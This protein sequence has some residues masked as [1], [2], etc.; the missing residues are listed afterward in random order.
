MG[1][2]MQVKIVSPDSE[3][4]GAVDFSPHACCPTPIGCP[5]CLPDSQGPESRDK[6]RCCI[7]SCSRPESSELT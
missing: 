5:S 6:P 1:F 7:G 4:I 2:R 3:P